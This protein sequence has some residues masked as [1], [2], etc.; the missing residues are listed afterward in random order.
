MMKTISIFLAILFLA[1]TAFSASSGLVVLSQHKEE[2][3]SIFENGEIKGELLSKINSNMDRVPEPVFMLFG[4][5]RINAYIEL[6]DGSIVEYFVKVGEKTV[7][8]IAQGARTQADLEVRV[9]ESTIE[10]IASSQDPVS[11][12]TAAISS[13]EITYKGLTI[14]GSINSFLVNLAASLFG[15][16]EGLLKFFSGAG[17]H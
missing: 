6:D 11:E 13:G 5:K 9:K 10:R 2:A 12:L 8:T 1:G 17:A 14:G 4:N 7:E 16:L 3:N 15:V